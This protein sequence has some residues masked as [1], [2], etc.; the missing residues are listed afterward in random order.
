MAAG[1]PEVRSSIG[2]C[3]SCRVSVAARPDRLPRRLLLALDFEER[4][5]AHRLRVAARMQR[6]ERLAHLAVLERAV[7]GDQRIG[8]MIAERRRERDFLFRRGARRRRC[9]A[10]RNARRVAAPA[11]R[12]AAARSAS[13]AS[14]IC[15]SVDQPSDSTPRNPPRNAARALPSSASASRVPEH[16][17][18]GHR[19]FA[20]LG[21]ALEHERVGRIEPDGARS[22]SRCAA[23]GLRDRAR[24]APPAPERAPP[25]STSALADAP[26]QQ[27]A[28]VVDVAAH[29]ALGAAAAAR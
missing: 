28:V 29:A 22:A 5:R 20:G 9:R 6:A 16:E 2:L 7:H 14:T 27:V 23:P 24:T 13:L 10:R 11:R 21:G 8:R 3:V 19:P 18:A 4:E 17:G 26:H 12:P 25:R 1:E 15:T